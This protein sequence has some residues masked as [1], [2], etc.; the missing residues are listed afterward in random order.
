MEE[1]K[2]DVEHAKVKWEEAKAREWGEWISHSSADQAQILFLQ[3]K[4]AML[5]EELRLCRGDLA[6]TRKLYSVIGG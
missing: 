6:F 3:A 5:R 4:V 1:L 2:K